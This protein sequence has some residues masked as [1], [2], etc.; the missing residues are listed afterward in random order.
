MSAGAEAL[1]LASLFIL[2]SDRAV[3]TWRD[4]QKGLAVLTAIIAV[5]L[6]VHW[7]FASLAQ[8]AEAFA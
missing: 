8:I 1:V 4:G 7:V 3:N 6:L 5:S 2:M